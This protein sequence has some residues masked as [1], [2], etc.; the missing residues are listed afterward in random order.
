MANNAYR[1]SELDRVVADGEYPAKIKIASDDGDTRWLNITST[2]FEQI[3]NVLLDYRNN[4]DDDDRKTDDDYREAEIQSLDTLRSM[5]A[6]ALSTFQ[7]DSERL[8]EYRNDYDEDRQP[9]TAAQIKRTERK[10]EAGTAR[11]DALEYAIRKLS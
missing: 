6:T 9:D 4:G 8:Q 7:H 2:E 5:L 10:I 3:K 1:K 11:I